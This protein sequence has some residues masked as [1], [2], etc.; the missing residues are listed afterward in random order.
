MLGTPAGFGGGYGSG[1]GG[2]GSSLSRMAGVWAQNGP[3]RRSECSTH[4]TFVIRLGR[5][6]ASE[7]HERTI[8]LRGSLVPIVLPIAS[9][10]GADHAPFRWVGVPLAVGCGLLGSRAAREHEKSSHRDERISHCL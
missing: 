7:Y 8:R 3:T 1:R 10:Y 9:L 6:L 2:G 5:T 4:K